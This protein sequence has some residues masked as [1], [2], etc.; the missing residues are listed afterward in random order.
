MNGFCCHVHYSFESEKTDC[1]SEELLISFFDKN[2]ALNPEK[3]GLTQKIYQMS[4]AKTF[5][6]DTSF[7]IYCTSYSEIIP[8]EI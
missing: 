6:F 5:F 4:W 8:A 3:W 7:T 1:F 2:F